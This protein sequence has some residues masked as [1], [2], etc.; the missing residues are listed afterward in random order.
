MLHYITFVMNSVHAIGC[1]FVLLCCVHC[2]WCACL[3]TDDCNE[4]RSMY[5]KSQISLLELQVQLDQFT[6]LT[7]AIE[8]GTELQVS[9]S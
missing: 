3:Q 5:Q 7:S 6:K 2:N 9:D 4:Y 8:E 1:M